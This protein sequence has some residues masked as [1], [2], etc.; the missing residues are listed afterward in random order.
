MLQKQKETILALLKSDKAN[1]NYERNYMFSYKDYL[2]PTDKF[3]DFSCES[4]DGKL[5]YITLIENLLNADETA[6][7]FVQVYGLDKDNS[8]EFIYA[9]TLIIFSTLP[10]LEIRRIFNEPKDIF[11]SDIGEETDLLQDF[12]VDD[13]GNLFPVVNLFNSSYSAYYCWWD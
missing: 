10:L 8:D 1:K 6:K 5:E 12:V 7:I 11:P 9:D 13:N 2:D 3:T 4:L